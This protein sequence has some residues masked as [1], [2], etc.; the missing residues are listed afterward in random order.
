MDRLTSSRDSR[1]GA[2]RELTDFPAIP[3][4]PIGGREAEG[5]IFGGWLYRLACSLARLG[6][7]F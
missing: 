7:Y 4:P 6:A 5:G 3:A 1:E 2:I